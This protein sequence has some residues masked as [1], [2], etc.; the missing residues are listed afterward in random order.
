MLSSHTPPDE[1]KR[2]SLANCI[3]EHGS[4]LDAACMYFQFRAF[5]SLIHSIAVSTLRFLVSRFHFLTE[6]LAVEDQQRLSSF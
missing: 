1:F 6:R 4:Y 3:E 2:N 5:P